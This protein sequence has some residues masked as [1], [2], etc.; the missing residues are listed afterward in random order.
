M[1][2]VVGPAVGGFTCSIPEYFTESERGTVA[3]DDK[4]SLNFTPVP[5]DGTDG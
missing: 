1:T 2:R 5:T 4:D 3:V